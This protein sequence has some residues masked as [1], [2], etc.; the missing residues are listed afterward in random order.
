MEVLFWISVAAVIYPYLGYPVALWVIGKVAGRGYCRNAGNRPAITMIIPVY[1]E[2]ARL[3]RRLLNTAS[4][5]Y[6]KH[7]LEILFVSDGSSDRSVELI[8]THRAPHMR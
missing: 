8:R 1:N 6:P 2:E 7:L 3:E 4:L 5:S